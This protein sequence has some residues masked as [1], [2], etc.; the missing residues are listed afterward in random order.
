MGM[1]FP[2]QEAADWATEHIYGRLGIDVTGV[3][4]AILF[5]AGFHQAID[6]IGG[7][8]VLML[9]GGQSQ[10]EVVRYMKQY[11]WEDKDK[12]RRCVAYL[13]NPA[14]EMYAFSY[15]FGRQAILPL[16]GGWT[17]VRFSPGC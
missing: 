4:L 14:M 2:P 11:I 6:D 8:A 13:S 16:L 7:N 9:R 3:S 12:L 5:R 1:I 15:C 17:D 10:D